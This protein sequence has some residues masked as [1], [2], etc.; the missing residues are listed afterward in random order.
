MSSGP[1]PVYDPIAAFAGEL[2]RGGVT[3]VVI[4]PG[5]RS[6]PLALT[7]DAQPALRTWVLLDERSA[8]FFA[9]GLGRARGR[10]AVLVCTSGTAAANYLPAVVEAHHA[11]VPIIACTADR[12]PELRGWGAGQ[13]IDQVKLFGGMTRWA[14][15]LPV[16][17]EADSVHLRLVAKRALSSST[18]AAPGPVHLNWPFREPLEPRSDVPVEATEPSG[19]DLGTARLDPAEGPIVELADRERGV[20]VVGPPLG[21]GL[22]AER[23]VAEAV[24]GFAARVG[25]PVIGEPATHLRRDDGSGAVVISTADRLLADESFAARM[26]PDVVLRIGASPTTKPVRLWLERHRP[27]R[28]VLVDPGDHWNEAS[29]TLTDHLRLDPRL[30]LARSGPPRDPTGWLDGWRIAELRARAAISDVVDGGPLLSGLVSRTTVGSLPSN[31]VLMVSN[32]MPVRDLDT[33]SGQRV[34]AA[35]VAN[36]GASG[37]DGITSTALG[38]AAAR[39]DR[40]A[41][42][43]IGDLAVL[44]DLSGLIAASRLGLHLTMVCIDNDGGGIFSM[45]PVARRIPEDDFEALFRTRHGLDLRDLDGLGGVRARRVDSVTELDTAIRSSMGESAPGV[46]LLIVPVDRDADVAQHRSVTAAVSDA[47]GDTS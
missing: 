29:F 2:V 18:G 44:H 24:S 38:L 47:I 41:A 33:F 36:R 30:A 1:D 26:V 11:G 25:W 7:L 4:S 42:A 45:L 32:S 15:D 35:V 40:A 46:D 23:E 19:S 3:D 16:G 31:S 21:L 22:E 8:G 5:S 39:P 6:T 9:L 10:P 20:I 14:A 12:P 17:G 37:I 27:E 28:V 34:P 13:T 43:F